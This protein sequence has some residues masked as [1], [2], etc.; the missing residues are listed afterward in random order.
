MAS[1]QPR[2]TRVYCDRDSSSS[3][4]DS[5]Q[6][7]PLPPAAAQQGNSLRSFFAADDDDDLPSLSPA[8]VPMPAPAPRP[9]LGRRADDE[10]TNGHRD[11]FLQPSQPAG[12]PA[13]Y[14]AYLDGIAQLQPEARA[15]LFAAADHGSPADPV[16]PPYLCRA[17][18]DCHGLC[19][20]QLIKWV[21]RLLRALDLSQLVV[22]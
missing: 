15:E 5:P 14:E 4:E 8:P 21:Y 18:A 3:E 19:A 6:A 2:Y 17:A 10:P 12:Q 13:E 1:A 20:L 7:G 9:A 11:M 16:P 22:C